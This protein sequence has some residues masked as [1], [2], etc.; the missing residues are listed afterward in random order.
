MLR[1]GRSPNREV[2]LDLGLLGCKLQALG[3]GVRVGP[4]GLN[5]D[6]ATERRLRCIREQA[7]ADTA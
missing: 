5:L 4:Q 2:G 1:P 6:P 7:K 3:C